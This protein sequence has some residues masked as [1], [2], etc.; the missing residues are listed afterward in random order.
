MFEHRRACG[1]IG[2]NRIYR[3]YREEG[4]TVRKRQARRKA[5]GTGAPVLVDRRG[6]PG[7]RRF[8]GPLRFLAVGVSLRQ[9]SQLDAHDL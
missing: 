4:L 8:E 5:V 6:P 2:I 7:N 9:E 1:A 3:L